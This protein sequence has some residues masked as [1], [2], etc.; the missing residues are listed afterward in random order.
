MSDF[1]HEDRWECS[2]PP[3]GA[4]FRV[5]R[6]DWTTD[7]VGGDVRVIREIEVVG[8]KW[9]IE[10]RNYPVELASPSLEVL[11]YRAQMEAAES[12]IRRIVRAWDAI[13]DPELEDAL[14]GAREW[15]RG[16]DGP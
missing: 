8:G 1:E 15:L 2:P 5:I 12:C 4:R 9:P 3:P 13:D 6:A 14:E 16:V 10:S 11:A 7:E